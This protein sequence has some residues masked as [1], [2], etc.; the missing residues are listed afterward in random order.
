MKKFLSIL[1][2]VIFSTT[3]AFA[4]EPPHPVNS[5]YS[6]EDEQYVKIKTAY[7]RFLST[8]DS[9]TNIRLFRLLP[10]KIEGAENKEIKRKFSKEFFFNNDKRDKLIDIV[11]QG[12]VG[13]LMVA[14]KIIP[15]TT[16]SFTKELLNLL[17]ENAYTHPRNYLLALTQNTE[18]IAGDFS[19]YVTGV[20]AINKQ[21]KIKA[22]ELRLKA[23]KKASAMNTGKVKK[24]V[25]KALENEIKNLKE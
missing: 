6:A 18:T 8:Q 3:T 10:A 21:E 19:K 25:I 11:K 2:L 7:E 15:M 13:A 1:A 23:T 24:K 14:I 22:L 4:M 12:E 16:G 17:G 5:G 20:T 9:V